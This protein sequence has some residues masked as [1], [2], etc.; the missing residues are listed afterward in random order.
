MPSRSIGCGRRGLNSGAPREGGGGGGGGGKAPGG[1]R[2]ASDPGKEGIR[3]TFKHPS[4][5]KLCYY[6]GGGG[7]AGGSE[8]TDTIG[9]GGH[10]EKI[11]LRI[12]LIRFNYTGRHLRA[13]TC[14]D[15][16]YYA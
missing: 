16:R 8:K 2:P 15:N 4:S 12:E 14:T 7:G 11:H 10:E 13:Q 1:M 5:G 6:T 3:A 9:R